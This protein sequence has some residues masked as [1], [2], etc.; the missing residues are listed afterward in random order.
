MKAMKLCLVVMV[1]FLLIIGVNAFAQTFHSG[2]VAACE[3]CH[4]MH[5]S[6]EGQ[7]ISV[8]ANAGP[9]LLRGSDQ[10]STCIECHGE[11]PLGSSYHMVTY[12]DPAAG[13]PP[14]NYTPGGDFAWLK[15]TYT[16]IPSGSVATETSK[17]ERKGHNIVAADFSYVSDA[18]NTTAPGGTYPAGSLGCQSCH[19]PHGRY[20]RDTTGTISTTGLPIRTSGSYLGNSGVVADNEPNSWSAV[21]VYRLLGGNG[22]TPKSLGSNAFTEDVPVAKVNSTYQGTAGE[23]TLQYRVAY[24]SNMSE[25]CS[26]C[27]ANMHRPSYSSGKAALTHPS[28]A[29]L[30][31]AVVANYNAYKKSG[32]MTGV[33]ASSGNTLIPYEIGST[34][35]AAIASL[36]V[37]SATFAGPVDTA[38]KVMCLSCHRAHASGFDSMLRFGLG[39]EFITVADSAGIVSW[40]DLTANPDQA[41]GRTALETQAAYY[42]RLPTAFAPYQRVLCNKCHAKD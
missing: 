2:G 18:A 31:A 13:T 39:N 9:Y 32:D 41:R 15:K 5:N 40:P 3:G 28:G 8:G 26:N 35:Y 1:T 21:G 25:W 37:N 4:T 42:N 30:T 17:G 34:D 6:L 11:T 33:V 24:G 36:A 16:W 27:H 22:Y 38:A 29:P 7:K 19:D 20:R 23:Q 12:P 10:S 14:G